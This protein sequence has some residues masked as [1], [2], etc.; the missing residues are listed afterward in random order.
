MSLIP[1]DPKD[2]KY[3]MLGLRIAGDFG[4]SIALPVIIFVIVGQYL[5]GKYDKT[6]LYTIIAFI[7]AALLSGRIIYKK[8]KQY[9]KEYENIENKNEK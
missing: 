2:R 4:A 7:L 6:P 1:Q 3:M 5:D 9:S 8:A